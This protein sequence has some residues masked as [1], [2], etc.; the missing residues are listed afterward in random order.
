MRKLS[1]ALVLILA[2]ACWPKSLPAANPEARAVWVTRWEYTTATYSSL[3]TSHKA[4]IRRIM[5]RAVEG[6]FNVIVFQV[7][8][9]ADAYY[10]SSYEPW[11][12]ELTST[13]DPNSLGTDPGW[14]PLQYA[15]EQAHQRGLELHAW[16]NTFNA[17]KG[18]SPPPTG[19]EPEH[20]YNVHPE[21]LCTDWNGTPMPL[22]SDYVTFSPGNPEVTQYVHNVAMDVV[23]RYDVDGIH[24]DYIR[25]PRDVYSRDSVT[26]SLFFEQYGKYPDEDIDQWKNWQRDRITFFLRDFYLS[27]TA[28]KPML[29]VSA[30]VIGRYNYPSSGWDAY[31]TVYQDAQKW[32]AWGIIDYLAPMI[33]WDMEEFA[34]L[35]REWTHYSFGR[36]IYA[37]IGAY[38]MDEFGGFGAIEAQIDTAREVNS[39]GV[40]F[41]RSGSFDWSDGYYWRQLGDGRFADLATVP[42]MWWKDNVPPEA[43]GGLAVVSAGDGFDLSWATPPAASDGDIA[44]YYG[45]YRTTGAAVEVDDPEQL[46]H[47]TVGPETQ[48]SDDT[49][50]PGLSYRYAVVAYDDGDNESAPSGEVTTGVETIEDDRMPGRFALHQNYPN[51]FNASTAI[52]FDLPEAAA[53]SLRIYNLLGQQVATLLE[54]PLGSGRHHIAWDGTSA[55]GRQVSSGIYFYSLRAGDQTE[56]K[57]MILI[58]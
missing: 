14:D 5:D 23:E 34:P 58:R 32:A 9:Q 19:I 49:A 33:Y 52:T 50:Q 54:G 18:S 55:A 4:R 16:L 8:G 41:F 37:G 12:W 13:F 39:N 51:P 1:G 2:L 24:W 20:V 31:N 3:P 6:N 28:V 43:P 46:I 30:A 35:I 25:Y 44:A 45:V 10:A 11:A 53:V 7:R 48:F 29:K 57:R 21:W 42:S 17:W 47:L 56:T 22:S 40:L 15:I 36:H 38:K 26:D 27:A